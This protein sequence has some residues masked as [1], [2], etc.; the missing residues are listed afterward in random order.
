MRTAM[1]EETAEASAASKPAV[2]TAS[3][4]VNFLKSV[5]AE[6]SGLPVRKRERGACACDPA[7]STRAVVP[8]RPPVRK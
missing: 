3:L 2:G 1:P 4:E 6:L 7:A 8:A 5:F